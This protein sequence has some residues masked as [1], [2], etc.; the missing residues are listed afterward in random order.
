LALGGIINTNGFEAAISGD[1]IGLPSGSLTK[2]GTG[3]LL[4]GGNNAYP[5]TTVVNSGSLKAT[6]PS[7]FSPN[8]AFR[9]NQGATLD[10][11]GY[12][13]RVGSITGAGLVTNTGVTA[14]RL[15]AG[16]YT[17][18]T[19][20]TLAIQIRSD[21][22]FDQ[23]EVKDK[24]NLNGALTVSLPP[25]FVPRPGQQFVF[26]TAQGGVTGHF[27]SLQGPAGVSLKL[28]YTENA[29]SLTFDPSGRAE[30]LAGNFK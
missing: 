27:S 11:A 23:L 28:R 2:D 24:A 3:T 7:G 18:E 8:S 4:L 9:I 1:I 15:T 17:Q 12:S 20:G 21:A 19:T 5:G 14:A 10:L 26:L 6:S 13:N 29:V 25:G 22:N 30:G 16:N